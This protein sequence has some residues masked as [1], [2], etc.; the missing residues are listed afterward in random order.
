MNAQRE[1]TIAPPAVS[2]RA[3]RL[4]SWP[5]KIKVIVGVTTGVISV[6]SAL[7]IA[8]YKIKTAK[9]A[10]AAVIVAP[11]APSGAG[12]SSTTPA[13]SPGGASSGAAAPSGAGD[14]SAGET[15]LTLADWLDQECLQV[16]PL[17]DQAA[18]ITDVTTALDQFGRIAGSMASD[19][20][21]LDTSAPVVAGAAAGLRHAADQYG[22]AAQMYVVGETDTA[23]SASSAASTSLGAALQSLHDAGATGC[24]P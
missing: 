15:G 13:P 10:A 8:V 6:G 14:P 19:L 9:H 21:S 3:G 4:Q 23:A 1:E 2:P 17:L 12:D 18:A 11:P 22:Y 16:K 20:E 5:L 24:S 7:T